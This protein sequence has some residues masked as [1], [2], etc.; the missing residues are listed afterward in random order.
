MVS[1]IPYVH[2]NISIKD[3]Q[4]YITKNTVPSQPTLNSRNEIFSFIL[5]HIITN[6]SINKNNRQERVIN[7]STYQL[8]QAPIH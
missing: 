6:R 1:D 3:K 4:G 7:N 2:Q 5:P 8:V